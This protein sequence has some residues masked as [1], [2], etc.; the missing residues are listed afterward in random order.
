MS[1][2]IEIYVFISRQYAVG[3][4]SVVCICALS[5]LHN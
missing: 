5:I 3:I 1:E 2:L 4:S